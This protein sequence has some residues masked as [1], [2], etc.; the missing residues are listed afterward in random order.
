[1]PR[2][3]NN[4]RPIDNRTTASQMRAG[5]G[6]TAVFGICLLALGTIV[7]A[8]TA[9]AR[10]DVIVALGDSVTS[11]YGVDSE[12]AFPARLEGK[13]RKRGRAVTV[14]NAG[15][16]GD[17]FGDIRDRVEDSVP[18]GTKLVIVQGGYNDRAT[19]VPAKQSFSDLDA[20]LTNLQRRHI[21]AVVCGF[22]SKN[23]DA[24]G[25]NVAARRGATFV[26]GDTCYDPRHKGFDGL[27]MTP[28]GH[29]VVA[30]RLARIVEPG[31]A[32]RPRRQRHAS[33]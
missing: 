13:L 27:H 3:D 20:I 28:Q 25:R 17:T 26:S 4:T 14:V 6:L 9:S 11:G 32:E 7:A 18:T 16:P 1:M 30:S 5:R 24:M 31:S 22:F 21:P 15:V 29:D 12:E 33:R 23:L 10:D 8:D 2:L 19:G